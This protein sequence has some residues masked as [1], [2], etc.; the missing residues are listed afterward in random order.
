MKHLLNKTAYFDLDGTLI[1][2]WNRYYT[3]LK[4][5]TA[6]NHSNIDFLKLPIKYFKE[7]KRTGRKESDIIQEIFTIKIDVD[8]FVQYKRFMLETLELLALDT[9]IDI[10]R[11]QF[12]ILRKLG[13]S[14]KIISQRR[15]K[16]NTLIQLENL[17]L[18][19]IVDD[20]II[21]YP[22]KENAKLKSLENIA[23]ERDIIIGDSSLDMECAKQLG[24]KG[25]FVDT[26]LSRATESHNCIKCSN[27]GMAIAKIAEEEVT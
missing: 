14:I 1:D 3:V 16:K 26:G 4:K 6:L 10:P 8:S 13:Y 12:N 17:N 23:T 18:K 2:V 15:N 19:N 9:V 7:Q 22:K 11:E 5:Y 24:M 20:I 21:V 25:Y 27:Y